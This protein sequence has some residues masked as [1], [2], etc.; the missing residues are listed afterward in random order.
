MRS[1]NFR[2]LFALQFNQYAKK[3]SQKSASQLWPLRMIDTRFSMF[4]T[5]EDE[6]KWR[7]KMINWGK[8][9]KLIK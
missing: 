4:E 7:E 6:Y 5:A 8:E 1:A 9:K 3:G 2:E